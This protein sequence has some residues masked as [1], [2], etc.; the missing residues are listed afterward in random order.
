MLRR[1]MGTLI[2][3]LSIRKRRIANRAK[4]IWADALLRWYFYLLKGNRI[5]MKWA[6]FDHHTYLFHFWTGA[7]GYPESPEPEPHA[8]LLGPEWFGDID[9][10]DSQYH[11]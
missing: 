1:R 6:M 4:R 8:E 10:A 3:F 9:M 11:R 7:I 2:A 5:T